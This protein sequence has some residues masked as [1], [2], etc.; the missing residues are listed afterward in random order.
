MKNIDVRC[1]AWGLGDIGGRRSRARRR[2]ADQP[3]RQSRARR[4]QT[5]QLR[6]RISERR[7]AGVHI[8]D[9]RPKRE[10]GAMTAE[11]GAVAG[12]EAEPLQANM[13]GA[14]TNT[15]THKKRTGNS[16]DTDLEQAMNSITDE[17][18]SLRQ[19]SRLYGIPTSSLRDHLFRKTRSR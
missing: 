17:A 5:D 6:R 19:A 2:G 18:M 10:G 3:R 9:Y 8:A 4:R 11:V 16:I 1:M 14:Q 13:G 15:R 12:G 7:S